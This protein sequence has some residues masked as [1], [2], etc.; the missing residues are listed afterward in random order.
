MPPHTGPRSRPG[1]RTADVT[2]RVNK[3]VLELIVESGSSACSYAQ[4]AKRSGVDPSTLYRR[5]PDRWEMMIDAFMARSGSDI[6]PD[7]EG[8]FTADLKSVMR[9]LV[10]VL[11][12]PL[13]PAL[14]SLAG[15]MRAAHAGDYSRAYFDR[16]IVQLDPMFD[17]AI[18]RGELPAG[19]DREDLFTFAAGA[20][21]FRMFIAARA[22]DEPWLDALVEKVC[23][24]Y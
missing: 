10:Q 19:T 1:G 23:W 11:E 2:A 7:L 5:Y 16:R 3:A 24:L 15:E 6:V 13:G 18:D 4:V 12:S 20:V 21:Y 17:A 8:S 9:R 22:I 14:L